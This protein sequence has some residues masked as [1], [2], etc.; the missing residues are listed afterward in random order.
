MTTDFSIRVLLFRVG[1]RA[2]EFL[3]VPV[4]SAELQLGSE[5]ASA[6]PAKAALE[7]SVPSAIGPSQPPAGGL[8]SAAELVA[9]ELDGAARGG[10]LLHHVVHG[11]A[12]VDDGAVVA[13]T[14][15][16]ADFL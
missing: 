16:V 13:A 7:L 3:A 9:Q 11:F 5:R 1:S 2:S 4:R 14:E 10:V 8:H 12:G 15:G 6:K